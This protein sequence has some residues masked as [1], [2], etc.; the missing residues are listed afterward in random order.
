MIDYQKQF[1]DR[2]VAKDMAGSMRIINA[3]LEDGTLSADTILLTVVSAAMDQI[4]RMQ[5]NQMVTLSE[6]FMMAAIGDAAIDRLLQELPELPYTGGTVILGSAEG[7]YHSLGRKIVGSFLRV[8]GFKVIDLGPSVPAAA[9]V[10]RACEEG[11][12]VI[13][14]S[15]LLLHTAEKIKEV[16]DLLDERRLSGQIKL[17]VGGAAFNFDRHMV[18]QVGADGMALNALGAVAAVRS[19]S[20]QRKL[21]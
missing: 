2:L 4:G 15:A 20:G 1:F 14:V 17:M 13:G 11:A 5:L 3:A 8:G 9:F 7:D 21:S 10:D 19:L 12:F 18:R 6:V 16:R